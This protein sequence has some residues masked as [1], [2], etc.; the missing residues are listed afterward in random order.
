MTDRKDFI[1]GAKSLTKLVHVIWGGCFTWILAPILTYAIVLAVLE[2]DD[3]HVKTNL[4]H[5]ARCLP[6]SSVTGG[7]YNI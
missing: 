1:Q 5:I 7:T 6:A 3:F 4:V 2:L